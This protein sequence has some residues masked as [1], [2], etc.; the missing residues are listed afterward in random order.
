MKPAEPG[1]TGITFLTD[2]IRSEYEQMRSRGVEF[3]D[4]PEKMEWGEW[5]SRFV[6]PDGNE[7]DLKQPSSA[8]EYPA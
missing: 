6:D 3:L 7:F 2:D 8:H 4:P 1:P 5:L